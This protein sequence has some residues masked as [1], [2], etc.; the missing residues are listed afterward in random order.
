LVGSALP[1]LACAALY[2]R[3]GG[4]AS[5]RLLML[6]PLVILV[7]S[8]WAIAPDIPR[9]LGQPELAWRLTKDPRM[10]WFFFHY[11][12]DKVET[13]SGWYAI[14]FLALGVVLVTA[15]WRELGLREA[16]AEAG[17]HGRT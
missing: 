12:I 11:S 9:A 15:A 10:D 3:A 2:L 6:G 14:G 7:C 8:V 4:R 1:F 17:R 5:N 16:G 13:D